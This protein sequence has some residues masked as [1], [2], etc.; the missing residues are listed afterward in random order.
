MSGSKSSDR[1][2]FVTLDGSREPGAGSREP[3][4][5]A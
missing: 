4:V 2:D 3:G 1:L 5:R